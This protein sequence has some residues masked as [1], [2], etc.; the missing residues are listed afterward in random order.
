MVVAEGEQPFVIGGK[1]ILTPRGEIINKAMHQLQHC[2]D[3]GVLTTLQQAF[4]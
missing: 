4:Q 2:D 3:L 1:L